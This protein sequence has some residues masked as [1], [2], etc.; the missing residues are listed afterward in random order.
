MVLF[1]MTREQDAMGLFTF[2]WRWVFV[3][4]EWR[5]GSKSF[6][7]CYF[8]LNFDVNFKFWLSICGF[9]DGMIRPCRFE[10]ARLV[11]LQDSPPSKPGE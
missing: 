8:L 5:V 1:S 3:I 7:L 9:G 11:R 6:I 4:W 2:L 10:R